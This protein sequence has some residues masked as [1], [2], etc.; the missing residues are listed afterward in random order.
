M[1]YDLNSLFTSVNAADGRSAMLLIWTASLPNSHFGK[2]GASGRLRSFQV[3]Y[4]NELACKAALASVSNITIF[5]LTVLKTDFDVGL[6]QSKCML[7][8]TSLFKNVAIR[9]KAD[10]S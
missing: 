5:P 9:W 8:P 2:T 3:R 7:L 4:G 10:M 6:R 1:P